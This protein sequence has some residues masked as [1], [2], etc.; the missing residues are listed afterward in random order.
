MV[1]TTSLNF[2]SLTS[3]LFRSPL[4]FNCFYTLQFVANMASGILLNTGLVH[5]SDP[6][7]KL[8]YLFQFVANMVSGFVFYLFGIC[9]P[10]KLH[11]EQK[12]GFKK[13][14]ISYEEKLIFQKE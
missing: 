1:K 2:S 9:E 3:P 11:S 6:V 5:Y 8:F 4:Y 13:N 12:N 7:I 10:H 14:G